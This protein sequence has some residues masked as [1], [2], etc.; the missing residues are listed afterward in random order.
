MCANLFC[1][2]F[3]QKLFKAIACDTCKKKIDCTGTTAGCMAPIG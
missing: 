1:K 3:K 2:L